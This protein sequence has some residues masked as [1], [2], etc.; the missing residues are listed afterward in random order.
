MPDSSPWDNSSA[1]LRIL[2]MSFLG[3]GLGFVVIGVV[4][5]TTCQAATIGGSFSTTV[6]CLYPFK[7]YGLVF[8]YLA[9]LV[10]TLSANLLARSLEPPNPN[11]EF[12]TRWQMLSAMA[13][14]ASTVLFFF[15]V[16][17]LGLA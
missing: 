15:A 7:I 11:P 14:V 8:L 3:L 17:V 6:G 12:V 13:I 4:L 9:A 5:L 1:L 10:T 2:G 16:L